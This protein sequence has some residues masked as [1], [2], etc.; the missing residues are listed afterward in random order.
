LSRLSRAGVRITLQ[1]AQQRLAAGLEWER[2]G[3]LEW[4]GDDRRALP[5]L[6]EALAPWTREATPAQMR[7]A[8]LAPGTSAWWHENA[9]WIEPAALVRSWLREP[10]VRFEG[11]RAVARIVGTGTRWTLEDVQGTRL[12]EAAF[13]VVAAALGSAGLL[14]EAMPLHAVRGQVSWGP[15]D[16]DAAALPPF[17]V[18]GHGHF[19]PRVPLVDRGAWITGSTYVRGDTDTSLRGE[20]TAANLQRVREVMP[21]AAGVMEAAALRGQVRHWAGVRCTSSDRRPLVGEVAPGLWLSA[22][23]GSRGL[24]FAALCG[25]LVAARLHGEPLPLEARLAQ[26]LDVSRTR[27][28]RSS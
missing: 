12:G 13:V 11:Q 7:T 19:L 10:G 18:N 21:A 3:V 16:D 14:P 6:G 22:A 17:P 4:R 24:T 2:T 27:P 23:M 15:R 8:G 20:D 1:Q 28:A 26:A 9:A 25:E 5:P